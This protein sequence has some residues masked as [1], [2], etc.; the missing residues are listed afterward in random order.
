MKLNEKI[1]TCRRRAGLSQEELAEKLGVSRQAVSKWECGEA[2]P[3]PAKLLLLARTFGVTADWLLDDSLG[4]GSA[5]SDS[6]ESAE[7]QSPQTE[8]TAPSGEA[9][10]PAYPGWVDR[11]PRTLGHALRR[12][13]WLAGVYLAIIGLVFVGF[14]GIGRLMFSSFMRT[15]SA[16]EE[17]FQIA[18]SG[19]SPVG[20][21][22]DFIIQDEFGNDITNSLP[23]SV[24]EE[25]YS[26]IYGGTPSASPA[27]GIGSSG[28]GSFMM[29]IP[30][31]CL[32]FGIV[33][34]LG[35]TVL[36]V[37]LYRAGRR[38]QAG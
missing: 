33:L 37:I 25:I 21:P 27:I 14:G 1:F 15:T 31:A 10:R 30:N 36:A 5:S 17:S 13:G 16:M 2:V 8:R 12:W 24:R 34:M 22:S 3:E 20:A 9:A 7:Q 28:V 38:G 32:V 26:D 11:L 23:S 4:G 29:I 18:V 6:T 19:M 35:G